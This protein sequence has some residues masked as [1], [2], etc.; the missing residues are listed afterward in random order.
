VESLGR[1]GRLSAVQRGFHEKLGA[2]CGY[3]TPG[4][5]MASAGLL[6]RNPTPSENEIREALGIQHLPLHRLCEDHRGS[7]ARRS[8]HASG[9]GH[10]RG[11]DERG[12]AV[13]HSAP[14]PLWGG[15]GWG[16]R[17]VS[18]HSTHRLRATPTRPSPQGGGRREG[19]HERGR[20]D[21]QYRLLRADGRRP[22]KVSGAPNTPPTSRSSR[23]RSPAASIAAPTAHA[24]IIDVDVSEALKLPGVKAI[25]TG[26]ECDKTFGVLPIA[27]SEHP[28]ARD[29]VRYR[30]EPV[31]GHRRGR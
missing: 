24:E 30:G 6:R 27:R 13:A 28:L 2:Q 18:K 15:L 4:F 31:A 8:L 19:C 3:C 23:A 11:R 21:A 7:A 9:L 14:L 20:A 26:A 22:E 25:V 17:P 1:D 16:A 12:R 10:E 29:K 5:I